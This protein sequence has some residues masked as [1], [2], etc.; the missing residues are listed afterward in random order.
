MGK[1]AR[2]FRSL[3]GGGGGKKEQGA[4]GRQEVGARDAAVGNGGVEEVRARQEDQRR[5]L[6]SI[7][8]SATAYKSTNQDAAD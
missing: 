7:S 3:W 1:A 4:G 6:V 8:D 2:W 5:L